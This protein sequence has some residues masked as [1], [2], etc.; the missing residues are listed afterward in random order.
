MIVKILAEFFQ[1]LADACILVNSEWGTGRSFSWKYVGVEASHNHAGGHWLL[2]DKLAAEWK[3]QQ[4]GHKLSVVFFNRGSA[5]TNDA[6]V[7]VTAKSDLF[8]SSFVAG[9]FGVGLKTTLSLVLSKTHLNFESVQILSFHPNHEVVDLGDADSASAEEDDEHQV[10]DVDQIDNDTSTIR[11]FALTQ[12]SSSTDAAYLKE[13][14]KFTMNIKDFVGAGCPQKGV[15][16]TVRDLMK[17]IR[18]AHNPAPGT[19]ISL[20]KVQKHVD[21]VAC[22]LVHCVHFKK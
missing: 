18:T 16:D 3:L 15:N 10:A 11:Q 22:L 8:Q 13:S 21:Y 14:A 5:I 9:C 2:N 20:S 19:V 17:Q 7:K 1:N 12:G 6:F 4:S